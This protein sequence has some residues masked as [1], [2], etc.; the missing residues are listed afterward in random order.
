MLR[1]QLRA[2]RRTMSITLSI[3][4]NACVLRCA[5][6]TPLVYALRNELNLTGTKV[7]CAAEQCGACA[8]IVDG[9]VALSCVTPCERFVGREITTVEGLRG[10]DGALSA[11]QQALVDHRA[12]Q[13]GY[14]TPGIAVAMTVLF[15]S[16]PTPSNADI[17]T[18][19]S[20]HLCRCGC[21]ASVMRAVASLRQTGKSQ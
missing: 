20:A 5:P 7:G 18:K 1:G 4:G 19:L 14:C 2:K 21:H 3:N 9:E 12:M 15:A 11:V 8:V 16:N 10:K 6:Q 13:C 17:A